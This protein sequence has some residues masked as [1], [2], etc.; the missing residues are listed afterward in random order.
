[1]KR[2]G[3][4]IDGFNFYHPVAKQ[5]SYKHKPHLK[6]MSYWDLA[7]LLINRGEEVSYVK[8][9]TA[10]PTHIPPSLI[11]YRVVIKAWQAEGCQVIPG[12]FKEKF[13]YCAGCKVD[14]P[15]NEEKESDV[16]IALHMVEDC[17]LGRCDVAYVL[18]SDGDIKPAFEMCMRHWPSID[19]VT[20]PPPSNAPC[21]AI[22]DLGV[23]TATV[24]WPM[25]ESCQMPL[26]VYDGQG[27]LAATR[28]REYNP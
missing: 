8:I 20:V 10:P 15:H 17:M 13:V 2:A 1:M 19:L 4:Y 22:K 21:R 14:N 5:A 26:H 24:T 7:A 28:P 6:W 11:R 3:F 12:R 27:Y 23:R 18:S 16:N 9:F 25:V